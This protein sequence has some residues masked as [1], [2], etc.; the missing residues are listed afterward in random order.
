[1]EIDVDRFLTRYLSMAQDFQYL[2]HCGVYL[3]MTVFNDTDR[4]PVYNSQLKRAEFVSA[5][6]RTVIIDN[7]LLEENQEHRYRFTVGHEASHEILH[8]SYFGYDP[9]QM[10]IFAQGKTPMIQCR[11]DNYKG[12]NKPICNWTGTDRMEW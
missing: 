6:A 12:C 3:G 11:A 9:N 1:M 7:G 5:K 10:S 8:P 2:S 4:I